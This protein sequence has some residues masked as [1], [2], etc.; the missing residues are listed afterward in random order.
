[1]PV[2]SKKLSL[3]TLKRVATKY[4]IFWLYGMTGVLDSSEFVK[5]YHLAGILCRD[6]SLATF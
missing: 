4:E 3:A 1:M 5:L 6:L 2:Y